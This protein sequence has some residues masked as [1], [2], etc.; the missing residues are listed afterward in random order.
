MFHQNKKFPAKIVPDDLLV[1]GVNVVG[2]AT[3]VVSGKIAVWSESTANFS[4][5]QQISLEFE[6]LNFEF[7]N[8][9][10]LLQ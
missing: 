6:F 3:V 7:L 8:F 1:V 2:G 5:L 9:M 10:N 4:C